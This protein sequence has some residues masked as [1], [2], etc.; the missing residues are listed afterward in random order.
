MFYY[1]LKLK[2]TVGFPGFF[3]ITST[4]MGVGGVGEKKQG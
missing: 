4:K 2:D 3:V 1:D